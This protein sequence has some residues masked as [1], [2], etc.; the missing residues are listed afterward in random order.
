MNYNEGNVF[1]LTDFDDNM[2]GNIVVSLTREIQAQ[3]MLR[4]G[5]IDIYINSFGGYGHLADHIIELME[6]AKRDDVLVRTIV[7]STAFSAGSM[8]AIAG[9]PGERYIA[10]D[11]E[12]LIHYGT[13][14]S[15]ESTPE[16]LARF[17]EFKARKFKQAL[18]HYQKYCDVPELEI[19]MLDDGYFVPAAK[20]VKWGLADHYLERFNVGPLHLVSS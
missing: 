14:G 9:S 16:Q 13:I 12:H 5:H 7:P 4:D 8:V 19:R 3:R 6:L 18:K 17:T 1:F 15:T 20:A 2:E 10:R 11:G